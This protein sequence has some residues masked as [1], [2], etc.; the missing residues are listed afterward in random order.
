MPSI[1]IASAPTAHLEGAKPMTT[2]APAHAQSE[3][4]LRVLRDKEHP[5]AKLP[6]RGS[7]LSAGYDLYASED[8][9]IP[10]RGRAAV[11]TGIRLAIPYGCYGRVA[12]RSGLA[13]KHG[14]DVGAGVVDADYRGLLG[15]LLFNFT[16]EDF[17][18]KA[19]DRIA[20]LVLE[21]ICMADIQEVENLDE[22][23]RGAG[24]F[25]STGGFGPQT[26]A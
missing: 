4:V 14:I 18:I 24:G 6:T 3:P 7:A 16:D 19:G 23:A 25:G 17:T 10:K 9:T 21:R 13:S 1:D 11:Q 8:A 26:T 22:T 15:I 2:S 12:P 5:N 20:Q